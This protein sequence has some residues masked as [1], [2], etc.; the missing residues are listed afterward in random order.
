M[1]VYVACPGG[2]DLGKAGLRE[3]RSSFGADGTD[4]ILKDADS[5]ALRF[6]MMATP[7][8]TRSG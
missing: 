5:I 4:V 3:C 7:E 2:L 8:V 6:E 1:K